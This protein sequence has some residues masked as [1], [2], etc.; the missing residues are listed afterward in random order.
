LG[1]A[2]AQELFA[3]GACAPSDIDFLLFCTQSPDYFLPATACLLRHR[4]GLRTNCGAFDLNQGCS[5]F[6]YGLGVAKSLIEAGTATNVLL[7]A[8]DT[9][10]KFINAKDRGVRTLFGDA[11]AATLIGAVEAEAEPATWISEYDAWNKGASQ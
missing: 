7:I 3:G 1:F 6:V 11:A 5:G 8:A 9:Y 2:A 10:P 4:L